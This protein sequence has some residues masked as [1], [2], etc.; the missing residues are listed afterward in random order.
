MRFYVQSDLFF[1]FT[2]EE[3]GVVRA[4]HIKMKIRKKKKIYFLCSN[5]QT[6]FKVRGSLT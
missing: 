2:N 1:F 4:K 6:F 5:V 3:L